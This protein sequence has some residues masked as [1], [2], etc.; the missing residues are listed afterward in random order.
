MSDLLYE[1]LKVHYVCGKTEFPA[2]IILQLQ[3]LQPDR[4]IFKELFRPLAGN[5]RFCRDRSFPCARRQLVKRLNGEILEQGR[6]AGVREEKSR[7]K[8]RRGETP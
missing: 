8:H 3:E 7:R 5:H 6:L 4:I 1:F 2:W